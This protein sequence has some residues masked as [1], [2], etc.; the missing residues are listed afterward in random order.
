M[1]SQGEANLDALA[2]SKQQDIT[3]GEMLALFIF[4]GITVSLALLSRP[5]DTEGWTRLLLDI[6][7]ILISSVIFFLVVNVWDLRRERDEGKLRLRMDR[8]DFEVRFSE[9][10]QRSFDQWLS[11][12]VGGAVVLTYAGLLAHK[13]VG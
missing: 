1:L 13:W 3:Q 2:P 10:L 11:I 7:A 5:P 8:Q 4:A 12:V 6:F 9:V